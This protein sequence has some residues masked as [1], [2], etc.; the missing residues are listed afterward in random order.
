MKVA[1]VKAFLP[2]G[3]ELAWKICRFFEKFKK[4]GKVIFAKDDIK[5]NKDII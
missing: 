1:V 5:Y 3:M 4:S 2:G